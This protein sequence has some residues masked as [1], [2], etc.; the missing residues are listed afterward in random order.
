MRTTAVLAAVR[1]EPAI[2]REGELWK[3]ETDSRNE[4]SIK[5]DDLAVSRC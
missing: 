2:I 3:I 5:R 1:A 4:R